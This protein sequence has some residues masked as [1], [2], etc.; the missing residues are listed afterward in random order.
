[1]AA[2]RYLATNLFPLINRKTDRG[3]IFISKLQRK[4]PRALGLCG[5]LISGHR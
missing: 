1:M 4:N 2:N 5:T 3:A